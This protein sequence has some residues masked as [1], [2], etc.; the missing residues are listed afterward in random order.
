MM[1]IWLIPTDATREALT[2]SGPC[3][4]MPP[5]IDTSEHGRVLPLV[6]RGEPTGEL[7]LA[8]VSLLLP[9]WAGELELR[10]VWEPDELLALARRGAE[11][12]LWTVEVVEHDAP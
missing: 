3:G 2:G 4:A 7:G 11:R 5:H 9:G 8:R 6:H 1:E 10:H 12:G